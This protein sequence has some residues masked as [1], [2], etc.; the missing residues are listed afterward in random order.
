MAE[1]SPREQCCA[2]PESVVECEGSVRHLQRVVCHSSML[3]LVN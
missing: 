1:G 2:E 3:A